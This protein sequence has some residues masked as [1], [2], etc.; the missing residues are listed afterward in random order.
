MSNGLSTAT[1]A[2]SEGIKL[3]EETKIDDGS[4]KIK[5]P[6]EEE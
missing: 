1:T 4:S 2:D 6:T 5:E 3:G